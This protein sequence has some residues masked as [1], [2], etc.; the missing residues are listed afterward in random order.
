MKSGR[1]RVAFLMLADVLTMLLVWTLCVVGYRVIGLGNYE[2]ST[3]L[4]LWPALLLFLFINSVSKAYQ[5]NALYPAMP[6]SAPEEFRRLFLS[7]LFTHLA[8]AALIGF[9]RTHAYSR[10]LIIVCG[11]LTA[12]GVQ[13]V[14]DL[15]RGFL[16]KRNWAQIPALFIGEGPLAVRVAES[17][18]ASAY[19]GFRVFRSRTEHPEAEVLFV[20]QDARLSTEQLDDYLKSFHH[21]EYVPTK[22]G[23][24]AA[25]GRIMSIDGTSGLELVNQTQMGAMHL[26]KAVLDRSL[27]AMIFV[28]AIPAFLIV[29]L[30]IKLTSRGPVFYR[31]NRLGKM[32]RPI[33]VWKFRSMYQDADARLQSLLDSD[34]ALKAEFARDFK[35]KNDPRV[36][37]LGRI[38]RKTSIDELPQLINVFTG[39][40]A[41]VGP[42]PI[43]EKEIAYYGKDFPIFSSVKPGITGLWQ[44]SGRSDTDYA[45][46]VALDVHYVLNWS[47]WMDLWIVFR[48]ASAVLK[49]KGSY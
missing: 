28:C 20:C 13:I 42:R 46:R 40:M 3:Y 41:L 18:G 35:L 8:L 39:E 10:L 5:G 24:P 33:R 15:V 38:L 37:P 36:T 48:T 16:K 12:C 49:M 45:R 19:L 43:V 27:A 34:P 31:A 6:L 30:L 23:F 17:L 2:I 44:A 4:R 25:E 22:E 11:F 21:I 7:A 47:P 9:T 14:R 1:L 26:G 32:G 29:P